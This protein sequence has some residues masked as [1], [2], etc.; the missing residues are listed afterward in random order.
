[1][2][3]LTYFGFNVNKALD[4]NTLFFLVQPEFTSSPDNTTAREGQNV[5][6][7]CTVNGNPTPVVR[8]TKDSEALDIPADQRLSVSFTSHT[9]SL[10]IASVVK[11]DQGLYRC[12]ANNSANTSTSYPGM[13][14]VH[15]E[16][17]DKLEFCF[18]FELDLY[19]NLLYP[20]PR[21]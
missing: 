18:H 16:Y 12:V 2:F 17:F 1:M 21:E 13:L 4:C 15:C 5:T 14:T 7:N 11:A 19:I 10:I 3:T 9:S 6:L 20:W 8:W